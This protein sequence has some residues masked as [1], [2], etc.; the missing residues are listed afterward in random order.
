MLGLWIVGFLSLVSSRSDSEYTSMRVLNKIFEQFRGNA[1]RNNETMNI[2]RSLTRYLLQSM[3]TSC[4][5]SRDG[6]TI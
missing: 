3:G 5:S 1:R 4:C 6:R 2:S